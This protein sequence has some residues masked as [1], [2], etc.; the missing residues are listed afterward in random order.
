MNHS[1]RPMAA[2]LRT[3]LAA[4]AL[5]LGAMA[6]ASNDSSD[7][8]QMSTQ[9]VTG[10]ALSDPNV[11]TQ[12]HD[13][14]LQAA[15]SSAGSPSTLKMYAVAVSDHQVAEAALGGGTIYDH[16]PVFVIVV[17]GGTF[18]ARGAPAGVDPPE[19]TVLTLIL[20]AA[21][22]D[23]TDVSIG[24]VEPDLSEV[25]SARVDLSAQ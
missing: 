12:L 21:T 9:P 25:A 2:S 18:T 15:A 13:M 16:A 4:G 11:V 6:C 5:A 17:T 7:G 23:V 20:N 24:N 8:T 3:I 22:Y 1:I 19:G 10:G 14:A